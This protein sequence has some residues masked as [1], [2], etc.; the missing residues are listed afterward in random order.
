MKALVVYH[1]GCPDGFGAALAAWKY[2]GD[3]AEYQPVAYGNDRERFLKEI[4]SSNRPS[5]IDLY[6]VDFSFDVHQ[7]RTLSK[8]FSRIIILDHHDTAQNE[9]MRKPED[10]GSNK[11][12]IRQEVIDLGNVDITFDMNRAG[13]QIAWDYFF[14]P[15][16][17]VGRDRH[18]PDFINYLG[19]R[20]L[21][22][23]KRR[24]SHAH[25]AE[26]IEALHAYLSSITWDFHTWEAFL[27]NPEQ[28]IQKGRLIVAYHR[29]LLR[30]V[31]A[32][33]IERELEWIEGGA[34]CTKRVALVNA[35]IFLATD[36]AEFV[37]SFERAGDEDYKMLAFWCVEAD[38]RVH[39]SIRSRERRGD[40][41]C[42]EF[43][44]RHGG[45]G[46]PG[47]AG[48]YTTLDLLKAIFPM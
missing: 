2:L 19:W 3:D 45:G 20:D 15:E 27:E 39:V 48:F 22:W 1:R 29:Q 24:A 14:Q 31:A 26:G 25:Y 30:I 44:K 12:A 13:C 47:S 36:M 17:T 21:L 33:R 11:W 28:A 10:S 18:R 9:L 16:R 8:K 34:P 40:I 32:S 43:A 35:P 4:N 6:V 41:H 38:G 7:L 46:H 5:E 42:G 23:H 37:Y